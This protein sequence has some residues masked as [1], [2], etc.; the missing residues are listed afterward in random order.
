MGAN[1]PK[2]KSNI[3]IANKIWHLEGMK[4]FYKGITASLIKGMPSKALY[5]FFMNILKHFF[6]LEEMDI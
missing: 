5:F 1:Q 6:L 4:G 3:D 2:Y